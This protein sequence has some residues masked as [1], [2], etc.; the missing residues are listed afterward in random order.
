MQ[1]T[2]ILQPRLPITYNEAAFTRLHGRLQ[3]RM[4]NCISISLPPSSDEKSPTKPLTDSPHHPEEE[5]P[6]KK[7]TDSLRC[8][9]EESP[10]RCNQRRSHD[11]ESVPKQVRK[12][13]K[14]LQNLFSH[15]E[16]NS[17][18]HSIKVHFI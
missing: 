13:L 12:T 4:L 16:H 10:L 5:S 15:T 14:T 17:A 18:F 9:K 3:I 7:M 6:M 11:N 1:S 2:R 8:L